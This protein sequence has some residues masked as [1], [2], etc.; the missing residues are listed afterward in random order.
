V[1]HVAVWQ[2]QNSG[3]M[4]MMAGRDPTLIR[5][6]LSL[7]SSIAMVLAQ[8]TLPNVMMHRIL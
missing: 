8:D 6:D 7:L 4:I 2:L 1:H 3:M 5:P